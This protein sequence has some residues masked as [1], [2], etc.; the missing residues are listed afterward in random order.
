MEYRK[1]GRTGLEISAIGLGTEHLK[2][3]GENMAE[4]LRGDPSLSESV[5]VIPAV[6]VNQSS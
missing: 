5:H 3:T 6:E 2:Q 4:V 1:L